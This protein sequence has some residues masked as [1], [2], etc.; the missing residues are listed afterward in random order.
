MNV[1]WDLREANLSNFTFETVDYLANT[2]VENV[3]PNYRPGLTAFLIKDS[4]EK[5][6]A[7]Y[8]ANLLGSAQERKIK[9]FHQYD[10]ALK[11]EM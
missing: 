4:P 2:I 3:I 1:I 5:H 11:F 10:Q 7:S 9:M 6:I 8:L